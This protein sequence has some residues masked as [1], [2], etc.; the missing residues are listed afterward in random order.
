MR[1]RSRHTGMNREARVTPDREVGDSCG[2]SGLQC[3][4]AETHIHLS[5]VNCITTKPGEDLLINQKINTYRSSAG[6]PVSKDH[7]PLSLWRPLP[8]PLVPLPA[9]PGRGAPACASGTPARASGSGSPCPRL[10]S[11]PRSPA[12]PRSTSMR[13]KDAGH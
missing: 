13:R 3:F 6:T 11:P 5:H 9:P 2:Q 4:T 12:L 8:A 10:R 7:D 1:H